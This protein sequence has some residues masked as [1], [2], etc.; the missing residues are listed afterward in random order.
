MTELEVIIENGEWASL[1]DADAL[2]RRAVDAAL[3]V[4]AN[5]PR[6]PLEI[7]VLLSDDAS[8]RDLNRRWRGLDKP[9]N[10]LSFP[11]S[12]PPLPGG[13]RPLG[14]LVLAWE[15]VAREAKEEG[16]LVADHLTH[17][18]VHGTLHLLGYDH[19]TEHEAETMEAREIEAL[20]RLGIANPYH[21]VAA[22]IA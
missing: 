13:A 17:L 6:D 1:G 12:A 7:S 10:V 2:A 22:R 5:A 3:A 11:A 16:K 19:E 21:D 20:A 14:D 8:V 9:T 15:T 4:A 18:V